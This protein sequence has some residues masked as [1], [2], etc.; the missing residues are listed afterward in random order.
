LV[1]GGKLLDEADV[2]QADADTAGSRVVN[3]MQVH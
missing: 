2:T 3:N 1:S